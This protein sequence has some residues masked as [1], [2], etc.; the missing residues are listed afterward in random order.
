MRV[1]YLLAQPVKLKEIG[2]KAKAFVREN[3]LIT[4]QLREHLTLMLILLNEGRDRI[5]LF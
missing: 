1:C 2:E 4:R 3:F 5:E